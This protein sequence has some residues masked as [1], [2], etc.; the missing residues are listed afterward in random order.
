MTFLKGG[1]HYQMDYPPQDI[2]IITT[3]KKRDSLEWEKELSNYY[4]STDKKINLYTNTV[5]I[6]S[7]NNIRKYTDISNAFFIFDEQKVTGKGVWVKSFTKISKQ[8]NWILLSA[9][10]GDTWED[11]IPVF[12]AN[13]YFKSR[14]D[15]MEHHAVYRFN[16]K[17]MTID[18]FVG[19]KKLEKLRDQILV[20][21]EYEKKTVS[22]HT[23][24]WC[25]YD[26]NLYKDIVKSRWNVFDDKPIENSSEYCY[27]L[28]KVSNAD[29]SRGNEILKVLDDKHKAIIFY[30]FD[31]ELDILKN[32]K[33]SDGT[34]IAQW[35]GH[36]HEPIP[37]GKKW[38]YLVQYLA[39]AEGWN[40]VSTDTIIF[41]SQ[42]Y[43]YKTLTQSEGRID[44]LNT[45]FT[46]LY[47]YHL[48]SSS[49]IDIS[50][51]RALREKKNF[52]ASA[53]DGKLYLKER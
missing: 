18:R 14:N 16:G 30:N 52:N 26:K 47:Y 27:I 11:Y 33:Y 8:N 49:S 23:D 9:T 28:R 4:I 10:P 25:D 53:F 19:T 15:F 51:A 43:S 20:L 29:V 12:I 32:L 22:H 31:Y 48:K 7:W 6:D 13:G 3:A 5:I 40:C 39:G 17:F 37:T 21:M 34:E 46:D 44:R 2:Y 50:I 42:T 1:D 24:I 38:V 41:Y 35:N 45:P 36:A